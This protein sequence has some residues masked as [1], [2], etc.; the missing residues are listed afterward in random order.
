MEVRRIVTGQ[1]ASGASVFVS[2]TPVA[3][4]TVDLIPGGEFHSV[5]GA[6]TPF[7]LPA[8]GARP[9]SKGWFPPAGGFRFGFFT[10]G[11]KSA[12]WSPDMDFEA[13]LVE[14]GEKLP[15]MGE[16]LDL[17]DPGMHASDTVDYCVVMSGHARL[18]LDN[19]AMV[20]IGPGDCVVQN[21][22]RHRW[23][24]PIEEPCV[25]AVAI[26]GRDRRD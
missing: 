8:N 16:T 6:D 2:D 1:D 26:V 14:L 17:T 13:A 5:W 11:P 7:S 18:E 12:A 24:N 9:E 19:G 15:G 10:I 20:E 21:G 25:L 4:I 23:H 3:P 22:T